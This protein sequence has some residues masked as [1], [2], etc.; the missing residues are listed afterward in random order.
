M[1]LKGKHRTSDGAE[2]AYELHGEDLLK[3][4]ATPFVLI[5]GLSGVMPMWHPFAPAL[6]KHRPTLIFDHRGIGLS[7]IPPEYDIFDLTYDTMT[8]DCLSLVASFGWAQIHIL[9]YS[10]GGHILM[11][12]LTRQDGRY[13]RDH[14]SI[15]GVKISKAVL[16]ATMTKLP[17]GEFSMADVQRIMGEHEDKD[18]RDQAVTE[19]MM[20]MQYY[21]EWITA[22]PSNTKIRND[23]IA[24]SLAAKPPQTTVMAQM[25]AIS[26]T[27]VRPSLNRIQPSLPILVLHGKRDR[28]VAFAETEHTLKGIGHADTLIRDE[29][30]HFWYDMQGGPEY[31][32]KE[33]GAWLDHKGGS[34][35]AASS[36]R[37]R[38]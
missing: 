7:S 20:D 9:G 13:E 25:Q 29:V 4:G 3:S 33:L 8:D 34:G 31:W 18:K 10:M 36:R 35:G 32:V 5:M 26:A 11:H 24:L 27:D 1:V 37:A 17:R 2:I 6:G 21:P 14:Y 16:A 22:S 23:R 15:A 30:A 19:Y 28:M 38:L 12:L